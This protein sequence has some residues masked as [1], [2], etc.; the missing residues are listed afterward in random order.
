MYVIITEC[1]HGKLSLQ[2][3]VL[4]YNYTECLFYIPCHDALSLVC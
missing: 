4:P 3:L 2:L 1:M